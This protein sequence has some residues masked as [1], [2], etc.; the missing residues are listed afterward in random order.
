MPTPN[1]PKKTP[2]RRLDLHGI[3]GKPSSCLKSSH[4]LLQTLRKTCFHWVFALGHTPS[5]T[6]KLE[7][8]SRG[9]QKNVG[10]GK[11]HNSASIATQPTHSRKSKTQKGHHL[12]QHNQSQ[13]K[14]NSLESGKRR[15]GSRKQTLELWTLLRNAITCRLT[16]YTHTLFSPQI[17]E[18]SAFIL[19]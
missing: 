13:N 1:F 17:G 18:P 19:S 4:H 2:H 8:L 12:D 14:A 6:N 7:F 10:R 16:P 5:Q 15:W 11:L 9:H 3:A